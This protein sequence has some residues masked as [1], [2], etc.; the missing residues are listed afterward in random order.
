MRMFWA[1]RRFQWADYAPYQDRLGDLLMKNPTRYREFMMF[2][3][4]QSPG[5]GDIYVG[6]PANEFIVLFDGFEPVKEAALPRIVDSLLV[7]DKNAFAERF[8]FRHNQ[9]R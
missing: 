9:R 6:V 2:S 7:A 1:K 5:V 3:V 4:E 8:E